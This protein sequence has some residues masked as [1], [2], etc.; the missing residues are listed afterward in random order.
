MSRPDITLDQ[1]RQ[2]LSFIPSDDRDVW[3]NVGNALKSEFTDA[4][5]V[6]DDWS[7]N[8]G[9]YDAKAVKSAWRSFKRFMVPVGYIIKIAKQ[10]GFVLDRTTYQNPSPQLLAEQKAKRE[11]SL[12][13]EQ[14][15]YEAATQNAMNYSKKMWDS[16]SKNGSS[17]YL[18]K[19]GV[20]AESIRY[21][22]DGS[23]LVP[24]LDYSQQ[25]AVFVG[26]QTIKEN[27]TKLF[28]K[29]VAKSGSACRLG[30][31]S[32]GLIMVCEGY[33]TGMSLRA[34]TG[35]SIAVFVAFDAGNLLK[36]L[37]MLREKYPNLAILVCADNDQKTK[38]NPGIKFAKKAVK[39]LTKSDVIYPIF[40]PDDKQSSDFND[41]HMIRG[42]DAVK[43]QLKPVLAHYLPIVK[44]A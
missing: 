11:H 15:A 14:S 25:P 37:L 13:I 19:K 21:L 32:N 6:F 10:N 35:Y 43:R 17:A 34:A 4:F 40:A 33:A 27:G 28:P 42:L 39:N 5:D 20:S 3:V 36:V 16:S 29:G 23:V 12:L 22:N 24:M 1:A 26:I 41:L 8:A 7:S 31:L 9:N 30:D 2:A 18:L 38:G 44:A